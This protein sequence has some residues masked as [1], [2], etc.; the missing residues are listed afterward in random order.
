MVRHLIAGT[1]HAGRAAQRIK[2]A[3]LTSA[4]VGRVVVN[5]RV[6]RGPTRAA[7]ASR[8]I[9]RAVRCSMITA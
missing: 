7:R 8:A 4:R 3:E 1:S 6:E 5:V 9:S 2:T